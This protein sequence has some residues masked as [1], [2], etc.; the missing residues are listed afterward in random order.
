MNFEYEIL[1]FD[2]K[3]TIDK[4]INKQKVKMIDLSTYKYYKLNKLEIVFKNEERSQ[5]IYKQQ[6]TLRL[7]RKYS[8]ELASSFRPE[9]HDSK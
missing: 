7:R 9:K 3:K 2:N 5:S 4:S 1:M 6:Y 8:I